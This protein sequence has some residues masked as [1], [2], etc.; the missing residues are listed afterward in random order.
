VQGFRRIYLADF[1][2]SKH[3]DSL[4]NSRGVQ[5]FGEMTLDG[6]ILQTSAYASKTLRKCDILARPGSANSR[7]MQC[8]KRPV[9]Q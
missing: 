8:S 3:A 1:Y 6:G 4:P 7:H 2:P 5:W 9:I